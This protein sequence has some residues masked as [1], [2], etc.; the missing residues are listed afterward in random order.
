M[1]MK[2]ERPALATTRLAVLSIATLVL[3]AAGCAADRNKEVKSAETELTSAQIEAQNEQARLR[4]K[5]AREQSQARNMSDDARAALEA[6][7]IEE[8]AE[9]T[10][11][12]TKKIAEAEKDVTTAHAGMREER[13]STEAE[14]KAR[15]QKADAKFLEAHDKSAN[16]SGKRRARYDDNVHLYAQKRAE[17]ESKISQL[18]KSSDD[19]WKTAK[20]EVDKTL[21][22][23]ERFADRIVNDI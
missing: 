22:A 23:L 19:A 16:L 15:M 2:L 21:D 20:E 5:Q 13:I 1:T 17:A 3:G 18:L 7:Q 8:R 12:G 11:E 10:E 4:A 9:A 6:K 14:A